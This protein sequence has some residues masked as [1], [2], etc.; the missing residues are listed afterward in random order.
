MKSFQI[1]LPQNK[2]KHSFISHFLFKSYLMR[3][4]FGELLLLRVKREDGCTMDHFE[5]PQNGSFTVNMICV[6][7]IPYSPQFVLSDALQRMLMQVVRQ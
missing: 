6:K 3:K 4:H 2:C 7:P 5:I 1:G